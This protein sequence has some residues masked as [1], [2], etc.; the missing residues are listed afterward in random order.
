MFILKTT[1]MQTRYYKKAL[2]YSCFIVCIVMSASG[3]KK[4]L[5]PDYKTNVTTEVVFASDANAQVAINGLYA[6]LGANQ[7]SNGEITRSIG[8]AADELTYYTSYIQY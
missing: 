6:T 8:M 2:V 3:C 7:S 1:T 4:F 5:E